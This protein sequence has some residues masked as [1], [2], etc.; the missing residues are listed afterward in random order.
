MF[1][2]ALVDVP[3]LPRPLIPAV[4]C[5][6]RCQR[7]KRVVLGTDAVREEGLVDT[8]V[9]GRRADQWDLP[10]ALL[11]AT[12]ALAGREAAWA[13]VRA[14]LDTGHRDDIH[15][16]GSVLVVES[17]GL[18]LL[19]RHRRYRRWGPL[20]GHVDAADESLSAGAARELDEETALVARVNPAPIDVG[21]SS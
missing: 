21:F 12:A 11:A 18:V 19:G 5:L 9:N 17:G 3:L 15:L 10:A 8:I 4:F 13:E 2:G 1:S 14:V 16:V 7:M 20:G 6:P